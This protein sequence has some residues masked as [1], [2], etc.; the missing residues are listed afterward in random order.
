[1]T[2]KRGKSTDEVLLNALAKAYT[3]RSQLFYKKIHSKHLNFLYKKIESLDPSSFQWD[4]EELN[5]SEVAVNKIKDLGIPLHQI[6][7][8]PDALRR[9]PEL[10]EYYRNIAAL[11]Q[12]GLSQILSGRGL[13]PDEKPLAIAKII[14]GILSQV[15]TKEKAFSEQSTERAF[16]AELGAEIQGTWVNLIGAGAAKHVEQIIVEFVEDKNLKKSIEKI[17]ISLTGKRRKQRVIVLKNDWKII[18]SSEPDVAIRDEK[19]VLRVAIEIKG[20]MDKAGA[21]TRYG[22]AKKSFGKALSENP[23]CE[24]IYLVSCFTESVLNQIKADGQVRK[25]YNLIEILQ[26]EDKKNEFLE[27]IF[28]YQVRIL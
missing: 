16:F 26:D 23:R 10:L 14:N 12:K 7:C 13:A 28:K 3:S 17:A 1:M 18:F 11:S 2:K 27:E 22:E 19:N 25:V 20:S 21:Q 9:Y 8:H 5:I 6:F 4:F 24:T 15:I